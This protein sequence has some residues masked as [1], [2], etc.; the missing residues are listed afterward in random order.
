MAR[1]RLRIEWLPVS[2]D[3]ARLAANVPERPIAPDVLFGVL[4]VALNGDGPELVVPA[5]DARAA[6]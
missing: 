4:W 1:A 6:A 3:T 2:D 5:D